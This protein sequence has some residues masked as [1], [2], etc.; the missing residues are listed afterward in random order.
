[1]RSLLIP[2]QPGGENQGSDGGKSFSFA[3]ENEWNPISQVEF[4][5]GSGLSSAVLN[6]ASENSVHID[7][8]FNSK[9]SASTQ[10]V[11]TDTEQSQFDYGEV[12]SLGT[13]SQGVEVTYI[14]NE[15]AGAYFYYWANSNNYYSKLT[16]SGDVGFTLQELDNF[17]TNTVITFKVAG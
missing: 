1:M 14:H 8:E 4:L 13:T 6:N 2:S 9:G 15:E 12:V 11:I 16:Y 5:G 3:I 10:Y 17:I 7:L